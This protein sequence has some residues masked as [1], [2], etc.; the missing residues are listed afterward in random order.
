MRSQVAVLSLCLLAWA[1]GRSSA[2][3]ATRPATRPAAAGRAAA[4]LPNTWAGATYD[5]TYRTVAGKARMR[6]ER[7]RLD[8]REVLKLTDE[9][10]LV[11]PDGRKVRMTYVTWCE[12]DRMLTPIRITGSGK[13]EGGG[14]DKEMGD[15]EIRFQKG[16]AAGTLRGKALSIDVSQP[17]VTELT[18]FRLVTLM[19]LKKGAELSFNG[20][21]STEA[22]FHGKQTLRCAG[23]ERIKIAGREY[24]AWRF[25][26]AGAGTLGSTYWVNRDG[27]FLRALLDGVKEWVYTPGK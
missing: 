2:A 18:L 22:R 12:A 27:F 7:V 9:I 11:A 8:G 17:V 3:P 24:E 1:A 19:P 26:H 5:Y 6:N 15:L 20:M 25:D 23:K 13:A 14:A 10:F 21:Q 16:K 4:D